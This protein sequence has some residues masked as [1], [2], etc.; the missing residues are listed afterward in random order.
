M[1]AI[2]QADNVQQKTEYYFNIL[3]FVEWSFCAPLFSLH[4][5]KYRNYA[6]IHIHIYNR[7]H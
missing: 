6:L 3:F 7:Q 2:F 4:L 5:Y 1:M